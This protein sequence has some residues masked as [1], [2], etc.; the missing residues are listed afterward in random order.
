[1]TV[2]LCINGSSFRFNGDPMT[3]LVDLLRSDRFL[4]GTKAVCREGFCGACTV[5]VDGEAVMSCLQPVGLLEG[6]TVTSIEAMST[7]D[8]PLHPLQAAFEAAD[9][10]QCGMCF[11][12][13]VMSLSHF[14]RE[15]PD[16][17]RTE[18]KAAMVG[19]ICRCTGYERIIDA[20]M[21]VMEGA[22]RYD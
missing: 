19:N 15:K 9:A 10:V 20:V 2:T 1:M 13:M 16:A 12:G 6:A 17:N 18:V 21:G 14:L 3:P 8:G 22:G 4:T 5:H 11:P 7:G